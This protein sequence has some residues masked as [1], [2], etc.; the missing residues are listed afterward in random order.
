[1]LHLLLTTSIWP[2]HNV[3]IDWLSSVWRSRVIKNSPSLRMQ[4]NVHFVLNGVQL[5]SHFDIARGVMIFILIS[6]ESHWRSCSIL[7]TYL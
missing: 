6:A 4:V 1:M 3:I 5:I 7:T 2:I